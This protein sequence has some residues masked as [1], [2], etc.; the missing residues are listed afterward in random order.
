MPASPGL[1]VLR[2]PEWT[3]LIAATFFA[4]GSTAF[5]YLLLHSRRIPVPLAWP[6]VIGSALL[7]AGL[8]LPGLL[9]KGVWVR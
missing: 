3:P 6:G 2:L 1:L 7:V 4:L 5:S 9:V 8:P